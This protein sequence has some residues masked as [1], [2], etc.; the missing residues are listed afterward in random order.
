[1]T[2]HASDARRPV[3]L[4]ADTIRAIV[5]WNQRRA[6]PRQR[7]SAR[8][9]STAPTPRPTRLSCGTATT[10]WC[11]APRRAGWACPAV[12]LEPDSLLGVGLHAAAPNRSATAAPT[13][14]SS[15]ASCRPSGPATRAT[16]PTRTRAAEC[17]RVSRCGRS[18]TS[19]TR[20]GW[21]L[22]AVR[23]DRP[24][25]RPPRSRDRLSRPRALGDQG[26]AGVRPR[27]ATT[28]C[29]ARRRRWAARPATC[30]RVRSPRRR[31]CAP[32]CA[33][34]LM[35]ARSKARAPRRSNARAPPTSRDGVQPSPLHTRRAASPPPPRAPR[36]EITISSAS[37]LERSSA[38]PRLA[39]RVSGNLP[40]YYTEFGFQT[41]PPDDIFGVSLTQQADYINQSDWIAYKDSTSA[42]LPSTSCATRPR[43]AGFQTGLRFLDWSAKP[44]YRRLPH[45]DLGRRGQ[46]TDGSASG[47][48]S[49]RPRTTRRDRPD[50]ARP[51]PA[52]TSAPSP[53][54]RPSTQGLHQRPAGGEVR[55]VASAVDPD[56]GW[57]GDRQP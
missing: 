30:A 27:P 33:S 46:P 22:A 16:T 5:F 32:C 50:P 48:R 24:A 1:M 6:L 45:A 3:L 13:S 15:S 14:R 49:G 40:I 47:V 35:A 23:E 56:D 25:S 8:R 2:R 19:P 9:D 42:R 39:D 26:P 54:R 37:R 38:R 7:A 21:L 29:S 43:L 20:A 10:G 34:R 44:A 57:P 53:R 36:D 17:C 28:S 55:Q 11:A 4:G 51:S 12:A 52:A 41:N 18:G 31:S